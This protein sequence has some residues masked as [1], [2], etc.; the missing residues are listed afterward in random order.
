MLRLAYR[1][2][3]DWPPLAWL[4]RLPPRGAPD[5]STVLVTHGSRVETR[6]DARA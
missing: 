4:A 2:A 5:D 6:D 3:P 1:P